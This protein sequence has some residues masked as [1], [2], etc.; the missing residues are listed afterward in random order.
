MSDTHVLATAGDLTVLRWP[1]LDDAG[2][3]AVVTTRHG[4]VSAP[5]YDTLNLGLHVGD[6]PA[7]VVENRRRA[8]AAIGL[9]LDHLV[10]GHQAHGRTVTVVGT[11]ERGRGTTHDDDAIQATD[12]LVTTE[13]D[14]GL[15]AMVADCVPLVLVDPT[16]RVLAT[17]HAGWRGTV[18]GVTTAAVEAMRR[19]GARP[20]EIRGGIGPAI[21]PARYQVG[22]EVAEA[23]R[24]AFGGDADRLVEP[25]GSGRWTFDLWSA[26]RLQL[27][28]AGVPQEQV[29]VAALDTVDG[30][31]FSDRAVRP[32]GRFAALARLR[33]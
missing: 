2:V 12:A 15:V 22:P 13:P 7:R 14:V 18:A 17:V 31:F 26:N 19:L 29:A 6:D 28:T 25:D 21:A 3:D 5:P 8:A 30:P 27:D 24:A 16:A 23:A 10:V 1:L 33:R 11:D 32:C 9:D 20:S 4:G